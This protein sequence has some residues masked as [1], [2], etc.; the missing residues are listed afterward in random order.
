[1][2]KNIYEFYEIIETKKDFVLFLSMLSKDLTTHE[3]EWEN[4]TLDRF[5]LAFQT[6]CRDTEDNIPSWNLFAKMFLAA[7]VYE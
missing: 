3:N 7:K 2:E 1:M 6:Y 4:V 5:L